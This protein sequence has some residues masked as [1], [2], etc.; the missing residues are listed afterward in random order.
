MARALTQEKI[1]EI[2]EVYS[3]VGI[4]KKTAEICGVS[5]ASVT[6]YLIPDFKSVETIAEESLPDIEVNGCENFIFFLSLRAFDLGKAF[7][8]FCELSEKEKEEMREIQKGVLV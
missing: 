8:E 4:K 2:N 5:V 3:K 6:K 1:L 7:C